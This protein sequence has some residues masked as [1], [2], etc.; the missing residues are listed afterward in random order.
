MHRM[1]NTSHFPLL[2]SI[3]VF[4]QST[5]SNQRKNN[6]RDMLKYP[7]ISFITTIKFII[8]F[9]RGVMRPMVEGRY[10]FC[11]KCNIVEVIVFK[12][13]QISISRPRCLCT[14]KS[15]GKELRLSCYRDTCSFIFFPPTRKEPTLF[16]SKD[17]TLIASLRSSPFSL[18]GTAV[19]ASSST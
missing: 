16:E 19:S 4:L 12:K 1:N 11:H 2:C 8:A 14:T 5:T 6:K 7:S 13:H 10:T 15:C 9:F 3:S 18:L 17:A